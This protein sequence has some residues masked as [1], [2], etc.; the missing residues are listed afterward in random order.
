[1]FSRRNKRAAG[2]A[3]AMPSI[4]ARDLRVVGNLASDGEIQIEGAVEGDIATGR[5][6]VGEGG[7]VRGA[8]IAESV[9]VAGALS[10]S[11]KARSIALLRQARVTADLVQEQ[12][13]IETG[14]QFEGSSKRFPREEPARAKPEPGAPPV[15]K[16]AGGTAATDG[17]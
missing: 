12:L 15:L 10:G 11:I 17:H 8:V 16:V 2:E 4:L 14:A 7:S 5:L 9:I 6:T 1:M 3:R 13:T